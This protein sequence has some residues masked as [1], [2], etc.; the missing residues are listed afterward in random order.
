MES[1]T[2]GAQI[3]YTTDG[4][5]PTETSTLYSGTVGITTPCTIK[6]IAFKQGYDKS[7]V[8]SIESM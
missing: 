4:T 6:A 1:L 3:R 7:G 2:E 5:E 8:A